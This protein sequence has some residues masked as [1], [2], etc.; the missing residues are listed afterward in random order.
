MA[1][2]AAKASAWNSAWA[3]FPINAIVVAPFGARYLA[4]SADMAPVR[5]AVRMVISVSSTG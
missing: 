1:Q 4:A 3:A 5:N 2:I